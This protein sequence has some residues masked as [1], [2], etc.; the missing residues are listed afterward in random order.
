MSRPLKRSNRIHVFMTADA[1]GGVWQYALDLARGLA[2]AGVTTTL[3][4]LGPAPSAAQVSDAGNIARLTLSATGLPLDWTAESPDEVLKGGSAIAALADESGADIVHLNSPALAAGGSFSAPVVGV[5]HSCV[6]TWWKA[7]RSG[8]LTDDFL[9]RA[10]LV[11]RGYEA[12]DVLVAPTHAFAEET[13]RTYALA[14][15]P[16]VVHNGRHLM[17]APRAAAAPDEP[18]VFTAG[19]LWDEGKNVTGL[20]RAAARLGALLLAAGSTQGPHRGTVA[21]THA[22]CVG[23]LSGSEIA[24]YLAVRPVFASTAL[25]E[26]FGLAVLEA[27]QAGCALV[28]SDIATFRELWEGAAIFVAPSD[29]AAIAAALDRLLSDSIER[30]RAGAAARERAAR[31]TVE[32]MTAGVLAVYRDLLAACTPA[33]AAA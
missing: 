33:E 31:Y 22:S 27:A 7:V 13:L 17:P 5:C 19:R 16:T 26:P 20:D 6:A 12:A 15:T 9:W 3:A 21:L 24:S 32:A 25:Y 11:R 4:V 23:T 30:A 28:L 29:D 14:R 8:P 18:F 2:D 10:D 1:V